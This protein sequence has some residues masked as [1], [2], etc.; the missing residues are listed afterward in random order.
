L[1][2]QTNTETAETVGERLQALGLTQ[3]LDRVQRRATYVYLLA[4]T[5][6]L[7][8]TSGLA[9]LRGEWPLGVT[10]GAFALLACAVLWRVHRQGL[11]PALRIFLVGAAA[12]L[13]IFLVLSGGYEN[14]ALLWCYAMFVVINHFSS[15]L[16]GLSVN[17][18]LMGISAVILLTPRLSELHPDYGA[19]VSNRF[20]ITG[21]IT[22]LLLYVYAYVQEALK[23]R[24]R[25]T[26]ER[27]LKV[28]LTDELTGLTNR[29][30]MK[31]AI[32]R[33]DQR[34][35]GERI[36]AIAIADIDHFKAVNDSLG[37]DAGDQIL[38]H[39]AHV[40]QQALR[41]TDRVARWGGEEFLILLDVLDQDEAKG[42]I[43]RA[44]TSIEDTPAIYDGRPV[45]VT[46]S[47]G[48]R[49]VKEPGES[50][51]QAIIAADRNLLRAKELG[52]NRV[53][54]S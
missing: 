54:V 53:I 15:A 30:S 29:R 26:Q 52:R 18:G 37:H 19:A 5:I 28:S 45:R 12:I 8:V 51:Q 40:L 11:S 33:E 34:D 1:A 41:E 4:Y 13:F 2:D 38:V 24:L 7:A 43:E 46:I 23:R 47:A 42:I 20:I 44:R 21:V 16:A 6:P 32:S 31:D 35:K 25:Q 22:C 3:D 27:L 49:I 48:I 36:L 17:L 10:L 9:L 39:I 50:L 14:T